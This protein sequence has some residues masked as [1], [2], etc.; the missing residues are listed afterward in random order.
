MSVSLSHSSWPP[1]RQRLFFLAGWQHALDG[2]RQSMN[3]S[4]VAS[5]GGKREAETKRKRGREI[6]I[7]RKIGQGVK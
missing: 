4:K 3:E 5:G 1:A 6:Q 7:G 2:A